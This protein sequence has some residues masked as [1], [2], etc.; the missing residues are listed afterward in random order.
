M[1]DK[2]TNDSAEEI[3]PFHMILNVVRE[4]MV[5]GEYSDDTDG[6]RI[7]QALT[8]ARAE[9]AREVRERCV[10]VVKNHLPPSVKLKLIDEIVQALTPED[11]SNEKK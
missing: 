1:S 5:N 3:R 6:E 2:H 8:Q 10:N 4:T 9:G 7:R 11:S